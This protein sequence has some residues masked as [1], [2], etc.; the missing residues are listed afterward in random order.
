MHVYPASGHPQGITGSA[1][2]GGNQLY[3]TSGHP[4]GITGSAW[5]EIR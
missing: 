1:W 3:T 2:F 5:F 4:E